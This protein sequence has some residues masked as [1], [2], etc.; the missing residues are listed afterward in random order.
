MS[1]IT[2]FFW[3]HLCFVNFI[4]YILDVSVCLYRNNPY[5]FLQYFQANS[6]ELT[7]NLLRP[8]EN[9]PIQYNH[10]LRDHFTKPDYSIA[11]EA[12][13]FNNV[14]FNQLTVQAHSVKN[15]SN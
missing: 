1:L 7:L 5:I 6:R 12:E 8:S 2:K 15:K 3:A 4:D 13:S 9:F 11:V 10:I 14:G